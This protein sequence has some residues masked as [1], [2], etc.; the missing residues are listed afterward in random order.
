MSTE[1]KQRATDADLGE[2]HVGYTQYL[3]DVLAGKREDTLTTA[4]HNG[5]RNLLKD[6][7]IFI[8]PDLDNLEE[9]EQKIDVAMGE[10]QM[11]IIDFKAS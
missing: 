4:A 5:I 2:I 8:E 10:A 6:N 11:D 7:Q 3:K 1:K 9:H